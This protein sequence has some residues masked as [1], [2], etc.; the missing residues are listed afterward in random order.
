MVFSSRSSGRKSLCDHA[1]GVTFIHRR[2]ILSLLRTSR[3][4]TFGSCL[5]VHRSVLLVRAASPSTPK[6]GSSQP[7]TAV[8]VM[9]TPLW[10]RNSG[11]T[12]RPFKNRYQSVQKGEDPKIVDVRSW[13]NYGAS[14]RVPAWMLCLDLRLDSKEG[15]T[16]DSA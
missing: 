1:S 10:V 11:T 6:T 14:L 16:A 4:M 7:G 5:V 13:T 2:H 9:M 15:P 3:T 8:R 12:P